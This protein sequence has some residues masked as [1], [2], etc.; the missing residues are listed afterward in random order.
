[1]GLA[2]VK[3]RKFRKPVAGVLVDGFR[4]IAYLNKL[5]IWVQVPL[6]LMGFQRLK[7]YFIMAAFRCCVGIT[8]GIMNFEHKLERQTAQTKWGCSCCGT[9]TFK[10]VPLYSQESRE[11]T[12]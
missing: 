11:V 6:I 7:K 12:P 9:V 5:I 8:I 10:W 1:M 2:S 4:E 3:T